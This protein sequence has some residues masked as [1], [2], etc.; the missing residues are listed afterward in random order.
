MIDFETIE[1]RNQKILD[2]LLAYEHNVIFIECITEDNGGKQFTV[3][4]KGAIDLLRYLDAFYGVHIRKNLQA[5]L[6][7]MNPSMNLRVGFSEYP[8][9]YKLYS[10]TNN[11]DSKRETGVNIDKNTFE[12][13][14]RKEYDMLDG[15]IYKFVD[16]KPVSYYEEFKGKWSGTQTWTSS[17]GRE[18]EII[19]V[20]LVTAHKDFI[21]EFTKQIGVV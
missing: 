8:N 5:I 3:R 16:G 9:Q 13:L 19:P 4:F 6:T 20:G 1:E 10:L 12:I 18:Y 7:N 14:E 2:Y 21:S 17:K 11:P 15:K